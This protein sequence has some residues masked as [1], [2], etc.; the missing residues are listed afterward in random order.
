MKIW[1]RRRAE[2]TAAQEAMLK[3]FRHIG[4]FRGD[5]KLSTWLVQIVMNEA[6]LKLRRERRIRCESLDEI[7]INETGEHSPREIPD[8]K[9]TPS[10][11]LENKQLRA[12]LRVACDALSPP[13]RQVFLLREVGQL[14]VQETAEALGINRAMVRSRLFRARLRMRQMLSALVA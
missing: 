7:W 6:R 14:S 4:G 2:M 1:Q 5:S 11:A 3:A 10:K 13:Y 12:R 8:R 9:E